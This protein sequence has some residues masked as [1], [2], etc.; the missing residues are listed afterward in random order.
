M[1]K[2][3]ILGDVHL[4]KSQNLGTSNLSSNL[5][6][7]LRDQNKLLDWTLQKAE[8]EVV[9]DII[10][11]GDIFEDTNPKYDIINIFLNWLNKTKQIGINVH[12]VFGN[13]DYTRINNIYYSPLDIID[14]TQLD[15]VT[16]YSSPAT[17]VVDD[18]YISLFPFCDRKSLFTNS[19][20]EAKEIVKSH[21]EYEYSLIPNAK[22]SIAIGHLA[23]EGSLYIGDEIDDLTNEIIVP[24]DYFNYDYVWM[25]HVHKF[26][27][28][29]NNMYHIGSMDISDF[30]EAN[31]SKYII[32][33]DCKNK[34][35]E[36]VL[37]PTV[38]LNKISLEISNDNIDSIEEL[39]SNISNQ[40]VSLEIKYK[41]DVKPIGKSKLKTLLQKNN[42]YIIANISETKETK[43]KEN[44]KT[45]KFK[46]NMTVINAIESYAKEFIEEKYSEK[47][48]KYS[49]DLFQKIGDK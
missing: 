22:T 6:S 24:L 29:R 27:K 23:L 45:E 47:F 15:N 38:K 36:E 1:S 3:L 10:I 31:E 7:R 9:S 26:Q 41:Q 48:I 37:I 8:E 16:T 34:S 19:L 30:G 14:N 4:G 17:L 12:L 42:P 46:Q 44:K 33:F 40:I 20:S 35:F 39:I 25:G 49:K 43:V 11:T 13:H 18:V 5:N 32:I 2:I 21:I 28:L